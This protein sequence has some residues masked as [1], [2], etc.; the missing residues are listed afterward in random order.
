MPEGRSKQKTV[1]LPELDLEH[2][3]EIRLKRANEQLRILREQEELLDRERKELEELKMQTDELEADR[4]EIDGKLTA[5]LAI[6]AEEEEETRERQQEVIG[7]RKEIEALIK[8]MHFAERRGQKV[9]DIPRKIAIERE[10]VDRATEAFE[11]ARKRLDLFSEAQI[12]EEEEELEYTR[13]VF[14]LFE[15]F[16]VGLGFFL[17]G[18][19]LSLILYILYLMLR[20]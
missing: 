17:A 20:Q 4:K 7:T 8:E 13:P 12:P 11:R 14:S 5:A 10:I 9:E 1:D 19:L 16:K 6:L 3:F 15:G 2:D 18:A